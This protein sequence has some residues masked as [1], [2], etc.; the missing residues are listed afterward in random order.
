LEGKAKDSM[1]DHVLASVDVEKDLGVMLLTDLKSSD[2][3]I[4]AEDSTPNANS[5]NSS[6]CFMP[7]SE[8]MNSAI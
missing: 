8:E 1:E 6:R 2:Q 3:L 4:S 7:D 5:I